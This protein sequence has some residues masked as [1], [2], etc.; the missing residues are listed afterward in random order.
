MA[1]PVRRPVVVVAAALGRG[2]GMTLFPRR[3]RMNS[4]AILLGSTRHRDNDDDDDDD[5]VEGTTVS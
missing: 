4:P 2:V 5:E 3:T 1:S